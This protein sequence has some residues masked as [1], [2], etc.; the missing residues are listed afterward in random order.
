MLTAERLRE[1]ID[2]DAESGIFRWR[3]TVN[4]NKAKAGAVA[5][6]IGQN[7]YRYIGVDGR[8]Y[9]AHRLAWLYVHGEWPP[10]ELDHLDVIPLN[11]RIANLR[12]ATRS[13]NNRNCG[14]SSNNTTGFKGVIVHKESGR[15]RAQIWKDRRRIHLGY[16]DVAEDAAAAY[17]AAAREL[18]GNFA[19]VNGAQIGGAA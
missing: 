12:P 19:K 16:F 5:G 1:L 7:G 10:G 6:S 2:Y 17:D 9:L 18:H 15:F 8:V 4:N 3:R 14:M 11:N 13:E